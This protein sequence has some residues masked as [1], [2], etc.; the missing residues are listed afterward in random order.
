MLLLLHEHSSAGGT[1]EHHLRRTASTTD[2]LP[3]CWHHHANI[4]NALA[5]LQVD[6]ALA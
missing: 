3:L 2:A 6:D 5:Y 4:A 1:L